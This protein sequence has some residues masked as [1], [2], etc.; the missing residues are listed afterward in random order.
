M[1]MN[2]PTF[3]EYYTLLHN[4]E[5]CIKGC[6]GTLE[7]FFEAIDEKGLCLETVMT[8]DIAQMTI[9][10]GAMPRRFPNNT[11]FEKA[12]DNPKAEEFITKNKASFRKRYGDNWERVLYST[13]WKL[14]GDKKGE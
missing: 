14:F 13:A 1:K 6:D 10:V 2:L 4:V 7:G 12:P 9:P 11:M 5:D 3:Q 8:S